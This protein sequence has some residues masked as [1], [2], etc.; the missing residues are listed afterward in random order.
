[1]P[2]AL[3]FHWL[4]SASENLPHLGLD[5]TTSVS[6]SLPRCRLGWYCRYWNDTEASLFTC[7]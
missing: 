6:T 4:A 7:L 1:M 5:L 3:V 2:A